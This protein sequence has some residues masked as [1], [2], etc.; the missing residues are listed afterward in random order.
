MVPQ[1]EVSLPGS[2]PEYGGRDCQLTE[3]LNS[4]FHPGGWAGLP[5][6]QVIAPEAIVRETVDRELEFWN[7]EKLLKRFRKTVISSKMAKIV[8]SKIQKCG[9]RKIN[10]PNT[11]SKVVIGAIKSANCPGD[12]W[13]T[14][15]TELPHKESYKYLLV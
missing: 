3:A 14:E 10:N 15:F 1:R 11:G 13:Q 8:Y 6:G 7:A 4:R 2:Q 12:Y 5:T 9:T